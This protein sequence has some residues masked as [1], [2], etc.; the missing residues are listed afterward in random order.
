MKKTYYTSLDLKRLGVH[1][2]TAK[3]VQ[4]IQRKEIY[5]NK[6]YAELK[7]ML[8]RMIPCVEYP[9]AYDEPCDR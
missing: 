9:Q 4:R 2:R 7:S 5:G 3:A 8:L 6:R 1:P